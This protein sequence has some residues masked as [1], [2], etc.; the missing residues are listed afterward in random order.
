MSWRHFQARDLTLHY[1]DE[2]D[3]D[4]PAVI[5]LHGWPDAPQTWRRLLPELRAAGFRVIAPYLRGF[6]PNR[7]HQGVRRTGQLTAI[8]DDIRQ[9]ADHLGLERFAVVG[10]D[11]GARCA[12]ILSALYPQRIIRSVALSAPYAPGVALS[13]EQTRQYW[14]QWYMGT[15]QAEQALASR[16]ETF[17]RELWQRWSPDWA[18]GDED[19]APAKAAMDNP[20]WAQITRHSYT[21]RWGNA[22]SDPAY[23]DQEAALKA[24]PNIS[25]PTLII[26]GQADRCNLAEGFHDLRA[27]AGPLQRLELPG[28][29]HFPQHEAPEAVNEAIVKWLQA[30]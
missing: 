2:G 3:A 24:A 26:Y 6:G 20:D 25:V 14:Y 11:W 4:Q 5:A 29:G 16:R 27:F 30:A 13:W 7:L 18:F 21:Q 12:Y 23:A 1:L 22:E 17:C 28:I 10:H 8:A 19:F 15:V 9:L